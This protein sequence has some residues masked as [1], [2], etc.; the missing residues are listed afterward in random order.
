MILAFA[1]MWLQNNVACTFPKLYYDCLV[2][3]FTS[4]P[5][6][7]VLFLS[8]LNMNN[9][10]SLCH[11]LDSNEWTWTQL[12]NY[13]MSTCSFRVYIYPVHHLSIHVVSFIATKA[14]FEIGKFIRYCHLDLSLYALNWDFLLSQIN[15][16]IT[17]TWRRLKLYCQQSQ[18]YY[19]F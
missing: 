18:I 2:S 12:S 19:M 6:T 15:I 11:L 1:S 10:I 13:S 4:N 3:P 7:Y 9:L 16:W 17:T 14:G 8:C 5:P